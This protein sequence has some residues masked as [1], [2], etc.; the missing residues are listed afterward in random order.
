M[1]DKKKPEAEAKLADVI[2]MPTEAADLGGD[3]EDEVIEPEVLELTPEAET[4][5]LIEDLTRERDEA[6]DQW[7]R[8]VAEQDNLRKRN[9][10]EVTDARHFA[11]ADVMKDLLDV[12]DDF[13]RALTHADDDNGGES[14]KQGMEM[15]QGRLRESLQRRGVKQIEVAAGDEFNPHEHEAVA[16]IPGGDVESGAIVEIMQ[17]GYRMGDRILRVARVVVAQ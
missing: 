12:L 14:V 7:L 16:Q 3:A 10:R 11:A 13:D 4:A 8:S 15:I 6:K 9:R 2:D 5:K 17:A 1:A